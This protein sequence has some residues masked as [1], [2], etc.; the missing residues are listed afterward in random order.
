M[1]FVKLYKIWLGLALRELYQRRYIGLF[2]LTTAMESG[3]V[4]NFQ[5]VNAFCRISHSFI[6]NIFAKIGV[7]DVKF[8]VIAVIRGRRAGTQ[9]WHRAKFRPT[10]V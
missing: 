6:S 8:L 7:L 1:V 9:S 5:K 2:G 3:L 10:L 4:K